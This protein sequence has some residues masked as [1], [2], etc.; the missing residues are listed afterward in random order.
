MPL[1]VIWHDNSTAIS[2]DCVLPFD[3]Q[4]ANLTRW[5]ELWEGGGTTRT[6]LVADISTPETCHSANAE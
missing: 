1:V 3:L 5:R 4:C 2:E 6:S